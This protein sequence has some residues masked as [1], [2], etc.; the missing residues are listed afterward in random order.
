MSDTAPALEIR[1]PAE[2]PVSA[3]RDEIAAAIRDHQVVIVAGETGSGKTTQLPKIALSIGRE[4]IG[5]TQPRRLAART[6]AERIADELGETVG[7]TVGYKVRF[8][9]Q[10]SAGTR[11][12]LMTDGIL[13]NEMH[14]DRELAAYDTIIIDEAHERS[15][16]I[17]FLL[18]Y[19]ARLLPRRPDLKVIITSATIDPESFAKHFADAAGNPAPII[20]VSG[21][22]YPVE[23]R[24]RP[25]VAEATEDDDVDEVPAVDRDMNQGI[26]DALDELGRESSGDV[27]V[28]FSGENEIKD[29]ADAIRGHLTRQRRADATEVLPLYGRLSAAEQHRVFEPISRAGIRRRIVLAT[30]VAETSLTVPGIKYVIDTGTARISR[31]STRAKVQRLPIEAISQASATQRSGRAGRTSD[32][33]AI[34]LYSEEDFAKR[35]AFTEPEILRTNLAAVILQMISLGLGAIESFPFLTPPDARGVKDGLE[36]LGELGAITT[37]REAS[38]RGSATPQPSGPALTR[39]GRELARLPI[40]PRFARMVLESRR[41]GTT[42]EVM[43]IVAGLTIQDPRERPVERRGTA[44]QLHARFVD[45][46][47]DFLTL[48]NLWNHLEERQRE[49]SGSAF[50]RLCRAEFLN[51]LRVREWQ[52]VYRQLRRMSKELRLTVGDAAIDPDGIHKSLLAGLLSHLGLRDLQKK[53][54]AGARGTHFVVFPGSALAKKQ[55]AALMSAELVETSRLF[56]RVNAAIDPAW[57]EPIAGDALLKR[58]HSEPHWEKNQGAAVAYERVTLYGVPII[59]RR[60]VQFARIDQAYARTLFLRHGLV[61]GEWPGERKGQL[62]EF[63]RRN[64]ALVKRIAQ[65]EEKTRRRD[66]TGGDEAVFAFYDERVPRDVVDT[67]SFEAWWREQRAQD[68]DFLTMTERMLLGDDSPQELVDQAAFPS[69]WRQ[70]DQRFALSYRFEPGAEDD[71]VTV[72]VPLPLLARLKPAG[73]DWQVPGLRAELVTAMIRSLPKALRRSVVPAADWAAKIVVEIPAEFDGRAFT[74]VVAS[75]IKK[76]TY[77]PVDAGDFELERIPP[78]LRPTFAVID[79]RGKRLGRSKD[80]AELQQRFASKARDSVAAVAAARIPDALERVDVPEWDMRELPRQVDTT[81]GGLQNTVRGYPAL[82]DERGTVALRILAAPAE[83]GRQH[84][85]G[86][87]RLLLKEIPSPAAYVQ[88]HLTAP[89]KLALATAPYASTPALFADCL[90]AVVDEVL[91]ADAS[92]G[93]I[94]TRTDYE[95]VRDRVSAVVVDAMFDTVKQ[96]AATLTAARAAEKAVSSSSSMALLAPLADAKQQLA[97]LVYPGFISATGRAQLRHL[98]RYLN[99][100]VWRVERLPDNPGRDRVWLSEVQNAIARYTDAGGT[101]PLAPGARPGIRHA[102]W[103]LE[104]LRISLFA[105]PLGTAESVS[106]QR[107]AKVLAD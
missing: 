44:D 7:Q 38:R 84:P 88:E 64:R 87:R 29:A 12:K 37:G 19:L 13:L 33:I 103:M 61:D 82:V 94:F 3:K 25:L 8:T 90:V 23:V 93:L 24:Y 75:A 99:G 69:I 2:L 67:R 73:F 40:D 34:R 80:L 1:F 21:R 14:R 65:L 51:Y 89:E 63:D 102:R 70:E 36:L 105:Q 32:G 6:I 95:R 31:Y 22:T 39:I 11:I 54:Y 78:H 68:A 60:R 47:S 92:G 62:F 4:R 16:N 28:F 50:R 56:A 107:I 66:I 17:D 59:E 55:P 10:V 97:N 53:D 49:L 52:D 81:V 86:V 100:I 20:E 41:H 79:Q 96:V 98:P 9:D 48:L 30:N 58:T 71:G 35:A 27:L 106:V 104:E 77:A 74:A 5:H 83:Q 46:T 43:A 45:P 57:A 85:R 15:L 91:E 18:G 72:T 26:I 76:L 101:L 42:R